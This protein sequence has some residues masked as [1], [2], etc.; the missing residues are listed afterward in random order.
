MIVGA[1]FDITI[2]VSSLDELIREKSITK[3]N[4]VV[5]SFNFYDLDEINKLFS[6][7]LH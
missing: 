6:K 2:P 3:G 7:L 4:V 5:S 1:T